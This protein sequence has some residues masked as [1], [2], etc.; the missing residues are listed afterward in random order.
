[1]PCE[2][3]PNC[4]HSGPSFVSVGSRDT[5]LDAIEARL[6][7]SVVAWALDPITRFTAESR[8]HHLNRT[9]LNR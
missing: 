3:V 9:V 5:I 7:S 6:A 4:P 1:M 8:K 2:S